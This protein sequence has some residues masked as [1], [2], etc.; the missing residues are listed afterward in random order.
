MAFSY[1]TG[2]DIRPLPVAT[3]SDHLLLAKRKTD[4]NKQLTYD[5]RTL[6]TSLSVIF[7]ID[8]GSATESTTTPVKSADDASSGV[9]RNTITS[10]SVV[11]NS[12]MLKI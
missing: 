12:L 10:L 6:P 2:R 4:H 3:C 8:S 5:T 1:F 11:D 7:L 9:P